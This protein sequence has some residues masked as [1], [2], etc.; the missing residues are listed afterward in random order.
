M[1]NLGVGSGYLALGVSKKTD[2]SIVSAM[3][4]GLK[5]P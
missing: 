4:H 5:N 3:Y 2:I 1:F